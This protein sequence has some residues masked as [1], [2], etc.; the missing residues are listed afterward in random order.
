[1][2]ARRENARGSVSWFDRSAQ[3]AIGG[4]VEGAAALCVLSDSAMPRP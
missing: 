1:M 2:S 3:S 4:N